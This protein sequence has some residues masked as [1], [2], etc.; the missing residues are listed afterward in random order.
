MAGYL[1]SDFRHK[2]PPCL[3]EQMPNWDDLL[4]G[5]KRVRRIM[6]TDIDGMIEVNRHF[7][8]FERKRAG[9]TL[10]GGQRVALMHLSELPKTTVFII[11]ETDNAEK[12]ELM[13]Y[14]DG[15]ALGGGWSVVTRRDIAL[16]FEAWV[17]YA[18]GS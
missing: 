8:F 3:I 11:R 4:E 12:L 16:L 7:L 18:D 14:R 13:R 5:V 6:P 9:E 2:C 17:Y 15:S 10:S 1:S